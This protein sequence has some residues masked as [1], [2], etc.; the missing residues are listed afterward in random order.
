MSDHIPPSHGEH[1]H[2]GRLPGASGR[3]TH[4]HAGSH[5]HAAPSGNGAFAVGIVLN[6][7]F[8]VVEAVYG[9]LANS[10]A[11]IAD[12][13][14]NLSDVLA[15]VISW[16]ALLLM[17]RKPT[18]RFTYGMRGSTILAALFNA[19]F[20]L[21]AVG[22]IALQAMQRLADPQP[23]AETTVIVVALVGIVINTATA[24]MFMAGRKTDLNIR[25]AFVHMAGD[26]GVSAGVVLAGVVMLYTGWLWL[27]PAVSLAIAL[28]IV[29]GTWG[30]LRDAISMSLQAV[31][32]G[33]D[34]DQVLAFLLSLPDVTAVHDLH[35]WPMSTAETALTAHLVMPAQSL[36]DKA[37]AELAA[38]MKAHFRIGHCTIQVETGAEPCEQEPAEA[39]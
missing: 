35:I 30:L 16:G 12:A 15:L 17:R 28:L 33:I 7:A 5:S 39:L 6:S 11:L 9:F 1:E 26:A 34:A 20:L 10:I 36:D 29:L 22:A 38:H 8:V 4:N 24:L 14:H 31:P 37:L 19:I 2:A 3:Q 18:S 23:V 21:I 27:D 25:S 13:G 32:A